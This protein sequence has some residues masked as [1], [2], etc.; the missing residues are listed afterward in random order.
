MKPKDLEKVYLSRTGLTV[1]A[2]NCLVFGGCLTMLALGVA[3][4]P[5]ILLT[6]GTGLCTLAGFAGIYLARKSSKKTIE[7]SRCT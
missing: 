1:L 5:S 2:I 7:Q 3:N 6:I 4:G